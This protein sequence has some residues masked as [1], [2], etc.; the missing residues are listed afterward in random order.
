[1]P[2]IVELCDGSTIP[3]VGLGTWKSK[4]GEVE[5]AV[6][7]AIDV[8][9]R[10]IDCAMIYQNE[11]EV[12]RSIKEKINDGTVKREDLFIVSKLWNSH[13]HP[14]Y[15]E[16]GLRKT[17]ECL[18]LDYL[19]LYL[20]H[21]PMAFKENAGLEPVDENG[22]LIYSDVD[23]VDT[24]KAMEACVQ[25]GLARSIGV[26]NFNS[27]QL[28]RVLD[29]CSIKPVTNQVECH[30]YLNQKK[31]IDYCHQRGVIITAYSPLGSPDRPWA[32]AGEPILL[33]DPK[34]KEMT[35]RYPGKSVAQILIRYQVQRGLIVVPKSVSKSR[36]MEN[37]SVD[38]FQLSSQ[39][40]DYLDSLDC[41][42]RYLHHH[43]V[44]DHPHFPFDIEF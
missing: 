8:G 10:H 27:Q 23:Y 17:L 3:A 31:L 19:D 44:K 13:H 25:K 33:Q 16:V 35:T 11:E 18:G 21:S 42:E 15:V 39:D 43:W 30:P 14:D 28:Q 1:M 26:S 41:G 37:L 12:G 22:K 6:K 29:V 24:W 7:D 2:G 20:M 36:M 34:I 4:P 9:Y 38:D 5:Q 40:M 32:K